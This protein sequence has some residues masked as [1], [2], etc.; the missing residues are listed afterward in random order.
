MNLGK[1][2][3]SLTFLLGVPLSIWLAYVGHWRGLYG[4]GL[5]P[6]AMGVIVAV[7]F[8]TLLF[9]VL[10]AMNDAES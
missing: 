6:I 2:V 10:P 5:V 4:A 8:G 1:L 9:G 7:L 3:A